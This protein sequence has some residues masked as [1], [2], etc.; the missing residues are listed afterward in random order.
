MIVMSN[1]RKGLGR[2]LDALLGE[3][4]GADGAGT[5]DLRDLPLDQLEGGRYQPRREFDPAA[6]QTLAQSIRTQGVVQ[7]IVVRTLP[8]G[9]RYEIVAGERRWRAAQ[10]AELETIPAIIREISDDRAVAVALIEN[11]Q[12]EDLN[13][14]E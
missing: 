1:R 13:P 11:I 2:G 9:E 7:P 12:R 5:D 14:L 3:S 4:G 8:D 6:L 10:L